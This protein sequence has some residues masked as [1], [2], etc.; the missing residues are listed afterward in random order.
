MN[1]ERWRW[2]PRDL[3][4]RY[5]LV[6]AADFVLKV[7]EA[8]RVVLDMDVVVGRPY[9]RTPLFTGQLRYLVFNPDWNVPPS[10]ARKD[11]LPKI[12]K[13]PGYLAAHDFQLLSDWSPE[14]RELDPLQVDWSAVSGPFPYK[15]RQRPGP[16][17]ALG[18]I[19]FMLP[20]RYDV[21]LHDT[22]SQE[23]FRKTVRSFSS[24]CVR[25]AEPIRLAEYLLSGTEGWE[26]GR[27]RATLQSGI[28]TQ[29]NLPL[30]I[31][32]YFTYFTAWVDS[33][34][35]LQFRDD[36]YRRDGALYNALIDQLVVETTGGRETTSD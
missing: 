11:L 18:R 5:L 2:L 9:R 35:T 15:L 4:S 30:Q 31:P 8:G 3:G 34:G 6:N 12:R 1:M 25:V 13:D 10:I 36:I 32:V 16:Q 26:S 17:N 7:V 21:Y 23:L 14:A 19:K 28:T 22:P 29:V 24:G 27:I 33:Q 20:N